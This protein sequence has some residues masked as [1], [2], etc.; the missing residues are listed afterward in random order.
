[1]GELASAIRIIEADP[2]DPAATFAASQYYAEL[3]ARFEEGFDPGIGGAVSDPSIVPPRGALLLAMI[4][5]EAVGCGAVTF[6]DAD[7]AEIKRVWTTPS[8]RGTGLGRR[9]IEELEALAAAAGATTVQ[10][11]TNRALTE[12]VA[13][14]R[15]LGY[16]EVPAYNDNPYAHHWFAK[17]LSQSAYGRS[18]RGASAAWRSRDSR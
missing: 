11:D 15:R 9:L 4:G 3:A 7:T 16:H 13:M 1:M 8:V 10:L 17:S 12:A 6:H 2:A 5:D 14:Y 18:D